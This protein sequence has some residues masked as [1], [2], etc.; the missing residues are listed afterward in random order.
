MKLFFFNTRG[1]TRFLKDILLCLSTPIILSEYLRPEIGREYGLGLW[2]KLKL[3]IRMKRN[4]RNITTGTH[5]FEHLLMATQILKLPKGS[6]GCIVEC[7]TF[8]GGSAANL[9]LISAICGRE[10][11]IFDSFEG[12][13]EPTDVDREHVLISGEKVH[14]YNKGAWCGTLPEVKE[15]ISKFGDVEVCKFNVGYFESSLPS[16]NRKCVLAFV[17]VDLVASLL[18]CLKY[19]WP[20]L[21]DGSYLF[22]HEA[23]HQ[24]IAAIFFD[25][26]WW[27]TNLNADAPGLVGA[28]SGLGLFPATGGFVSNIG[29]TVKRPTVN[30]FKLEPQTGH[31]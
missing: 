12:L 8:K 1:A 13:P 2:Q 11:E 26:T 15:N 23:T 29:Y 5:P 22:V 9:S 31:L 14:S 7:G 25:K 28:G 30:K 3:G 16:F 19:L 24:E 20:L 21:E 10:L 18:T 6:D 27:H 4:T 17:D